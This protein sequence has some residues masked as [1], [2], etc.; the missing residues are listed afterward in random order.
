MEDPCKSAERKT[1]AALRHRDE[2]DE[3]R[4]RISNASTI[5]ETERDKKHDCTKHDEA[6]IDFLFNSASTQLRPPF[7]GSAI[8]LNTCLVTLRDHGNW[9]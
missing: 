6:E 3:I 8:L 1:N 9:M 5:L 7:R 4:D 2:I